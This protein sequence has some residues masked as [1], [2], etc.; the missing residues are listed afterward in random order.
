MSFGKTDLCSFPPK[1]KVKVFSNVHLDNELDD[2]NYF[3]PVLLQSL[4]L[5]STPSIVNI[6]VKVLAW[7]VSDLLTVWSL[8]CY[9]TV[10]AA[11]KHSIQI[12]VVICQKRLLS[13]EAREL[14]LTCGHSFPAPQHSCSHSRHLPCSS[15]PALDPL[16]PFHLFC[17]KPCHFPN[18]PFCWSISFQKRSVCLLYL[19]QV[20]IIALWLSFFTTIY[21]DL[22]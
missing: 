8:L 14:D 17:T 1:G 20:L 19:Y 18:I 2:F 15:I 21:L 12:R 13:K 5:W 3:K 7:I 10:Q 6:S 4:S 16:C 11:I 9:S 22:C